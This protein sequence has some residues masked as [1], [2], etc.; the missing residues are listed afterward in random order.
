MTPDALLLP[1]WISFLVAL[2]LFFTRKWVNDV[3]RAIDSL[4]ER[5]RAYEKAQNDC[6]LELARG[7]P[8]RSEMERVGE[9]LESHATRLTILEENIAA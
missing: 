5:M 3:A 2:V 6:R 4:Q 8:T 9:R 7:Y 1:A